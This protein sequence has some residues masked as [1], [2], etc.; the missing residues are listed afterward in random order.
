M[1]LQMGDKVAYR[2]EMTWVVGTIAATEG[3]RANENR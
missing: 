1:L 3:V 2:K